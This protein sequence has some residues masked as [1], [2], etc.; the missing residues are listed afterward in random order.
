LKLI[1]KKIIYEDNLALYV[2]AKLTLEDPDR[3]QRISTG[4]KKKWEHSLLLKKGIHA[5][6][7]PIGN[8]IKC[9]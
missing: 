1:I 5:M 2:E 9:N 8:K 6:H 3:S 7:E 4:H